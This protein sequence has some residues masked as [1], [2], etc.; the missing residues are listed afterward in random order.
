MSIIKL[1][2]YYQDDDGLWNINPTSL[3]TA[4]NFV[5]GVGAVATSPTQYL[6]Y[7]NPSG[8]LYYDADGNGSEI[9][10]PILTLGTMQH[11]TLTFNDLVL[12]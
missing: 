12:V 6:V 3:I 5:S 9:A 1:G 4:Q 2:A 11:P 10:M 8:I 7:D